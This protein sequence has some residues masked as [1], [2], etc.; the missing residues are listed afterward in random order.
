M[1]LSDARRWYHTG[2]QLSLKPPNP[3]PSDITNEPP[4]SDR[5]LTCLHLLATR[6]HDELPTPNR[7]QSCNPHAVEG[8]DERNRVGTKTRRKSQERKKNANR[9]TE[10]P[11]PAN[12]TQVRSPRR[13]KAKRPQGICESTEAQQQ[14]NETI[15]KLEKKKR[16][17]SKSKRRRECG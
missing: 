12:Q 14:R 11:P 10:Q 17:G 13:T 8:E 6:R 4:G 9:S 16:S 5:R 15:N 1:A 3:C 7:I 2:R